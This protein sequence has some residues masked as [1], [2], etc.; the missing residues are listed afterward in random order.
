MDVADA[1]VDAWGV[2]GHLACD[3]ARVELPTPTWRCCLRSRS[4]DPATDSGKAAGTT[5]V[6]WFRSSRPGPWLV[7]S[8]EV[9]AD[10]SRSRTTWQSM[11]VSAD[12]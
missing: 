9:V 7:W 8:D 11:R 3:A 1:P 10:V 12:G 4:R 5:T 6:S 2:P